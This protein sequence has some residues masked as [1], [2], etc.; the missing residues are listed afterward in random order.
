MRQVVGRHGIPVA[1]CSDQHSIFRATKTAMPI[2]DQLEGEGCRPT[3]FGRL[4][5]ELGVTLILAR[6][7]QAKGR[8]ERLWGTFQDRLTS[9]LRLAGAATQAEAEQVL[10]RYLVPHNRHFTV[11]AADPAP[12]RLPWPATL[13]ADEVFCF[14]Y[15]RVVAHDN[16]IRFGRTC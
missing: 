4:L 15:R 5:S 2:E 3:Q 12:A 8:I 1:V 9:E 6:S 14:K 11:P 7:P 13:H 16:A 10:A